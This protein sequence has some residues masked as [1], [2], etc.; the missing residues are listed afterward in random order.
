MLIPKPSGTRKSKSIRKSECRLRHLW[1][2]GGNNAR[3]VSSSLERLKESKSAFCLR[4]SE[5]GQGVDRAGVRSIERK[6]MSTA[7]LNGTSKLKSPSV[8]GITRRVPTQSAESF[9]WDDAAEQPSPLAASTID[10]EPAPP[11]QGCPENGRPAEEPDV[12]VRDQVHEAFEAVAFSCVCTLEMLLAET[13][14][15]GIDDDDVLEI[16]S[17]DET[18]LSCQGLSLI[19]I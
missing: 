14:S 6:S 1:Q 15:L 8:D 18:N 19:H 3:A 11:L 10:L 17:N 13:C 4:S 9:L 7:T 12:P 5:F 16:I 2:R